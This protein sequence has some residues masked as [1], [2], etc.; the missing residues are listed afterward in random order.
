MKRPVLFYL[1][2]LLCINL[3]CCKDAEDK[4]PLYNTSQGMVQLVQDLNREFGTAAGFTRL[5]L[6]FNQQDG[7]G[8]SVAAAKDVDSSKLTE[9]IK[10]P[11]QKIWSTTGESRLQ[12][13]GN[14]QPRD[15]MFTL[16][17]LNDLQLIP[18]LVKRSI[19]KVALEKK[20]SD[21]IVGAIGITMP[22]TIND[23]SYGVRIT[24]NVMTKKEDRVFMVTY[25]G[26]GNFKSFYY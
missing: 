11:G 12:I 6:V 18:E 13:E 20:L 5:L 9:M 22:G 16:H 26:K 14:A 23:S 8:I 1:P 2:Y 25:D 19:D 7:T 3:L 24:V 4:E 15:F 17:E 21:L 10:W